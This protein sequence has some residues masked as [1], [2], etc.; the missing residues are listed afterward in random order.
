MSAS[1]DD[2]IKAI[3][4]GFEK[5]GGGG[6]G[7]GGGGGRRSAGDPSAV[8]KGGADQLKEELKLLQEYEKKLQGL[9]NSE[10]ARYAQ[11]EQRRIVAEKELELKKAE[12]AAKGELTAADAQALKDAQMKVE[13]ADE[14]ID[15]L[16][17]QNE[18]MKKSIQHA[19]DFVTNLGSGLA[20][21]GGNILGGFITAI[22]DAI[23]ALDDMETS[24]MRA[25]GMSRDLA[26]TFSD[27]SDAVSKYWVSTTQY[28]EAVNSL[29]RTSSEFSMLQPEIQ[30]QLANTTSVLSTL[31]VAADDMAGAFQSAIKI[32]GQT[33]AQADATLL[34]MSALARDLGVPIDQMM[35]NFNQMMP[36]LAALGPTA[37]DSFREMARVAKI[38]GLEMSKLLNMTKKFDTFEGAATQVGQINAALGGNFVNAMDMMM[39][40]DPVERFEM[41]R[42]A[43]TDAGQSF[44]DMSYY[45]RQ[46]MAEAMGL[47]SVADLAAMMSGDMSGLSDEVG[48][49]AADYE[50]QAEAAA[51]AASVQEKFQGFLD[52]I[53]RTIVD[54]GMLDKIH[55]M[56]DQFTQGKGPLIEIK[57]EMVDFGNSIKDMLPKII[58]FVDVHLPKI[59]SLVKAFMYLAVAAHIV[60]IGK[61]AFDMGNNILKAGQGFG[62]LI[63]GMRTTKQAS[64]AVKTST[65]LTTASQAAQNA[66]APA[67]VG[68][69]QSVAGS[70]QAAGKAAK[71]S[72]KHILAMGAAALMIGAAIY[73]AAIGVA[74]LVKS[75]Q[76]FSATE[77]LAIAVALLV[78]GAS[79]AGM[80]Y[81][82]LSALPGL[83]VSVGVILAV[84][85]AFL[86]MGAGVGLAAY[87]FSLL[88]E[89][90][91]EMGAAEILAMAVAFLAFS[92]ALY[93]FSSAIMLLSLALVSL[94]NPLALSGLAVLKGMVSGMVVALGALAA[95]LLVIMIPMIMLFDLLKDPSGITAAAAEMASIARSINSV[96]LAK[97]LALGGAIRGAGGGG[98]NTSSSSRAQKISIQLNEKQTKDFLEGLVV[99]AQGSAAARA[100]GVR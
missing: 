88:V 12:L 8:P 84:G 82:M 31:G 25:T 57:N 36:E 75:F 62:T 87:G 93:I 4:K 95:I 89:S 34:S 79:I 90:F 46:F 37:A 60:S 56:F 52:D 76:G 38:T 86:M 64:D 72:A 69:Q 45:Q 98:G 92:Q 10:T 68:A 23:F 7:A 5:V 59:I 80:S 29:F 91:S 35:A 43:L 13:L 51:Q 28:G 18:E 50:A 83:G 96:S 3:E 100:T 74:E 65:D 2:I 77:I 40:T 48:M 73:V 16:D 17:E 14:M 70:T 67:T 42:G 85:A 97:T 39:S 49:T 61:A 19:K 30:M 94:M 47:D 66:Q 44:D 27:G 22:K 33:A 11:A 32:M 24:M 55:E 15:K 1:I 54:S 21:I 41:L 6:G 58:E 9:G 99:D 78:F 71:T 53:M 26:Q 63:S 81:I 20:S